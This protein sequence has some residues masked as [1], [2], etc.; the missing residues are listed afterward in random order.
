MQSTTR[1]IS[2]T[3]EDAITLTRALKTYL[4]ITEIG[5]TDLYCKLT[6]QL[7]RIAYECTM[8]DIE[9]LSEGHK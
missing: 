3:A 8:Q 7:Q 9:R 1:T 4:A 6:E 2:L 5:A